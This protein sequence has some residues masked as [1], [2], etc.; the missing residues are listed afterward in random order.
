MQ[1]PRTVRSAAVRTP[2]R[3]LTLVELLVSIGLIIFIMS[4]F[5]SLFVQAGGALRQMTGINEIDQQARNLSTLLRRDL[6]DVF[7][8]TA[9]G[10]QITPAQLFA[11]PEDHDQV[12]A[13]YFSIEEN[14][15]ALGQG[16]DQWG[17]RVAV[18]T[19]DVL[20][21]TARRS[22]RSAQDLFFGRVPPEPLTAPAPPAVPVPQDGAPTQAWFDTFANAGGRF[23]ERGNGLFSSPF[24]EVAYF[25]RPEVGQ[26]TGDTLRGR[27]ADG[28]TTTPQPQRARTFV[29]CR[30]AL[31]V[32]PREVAL[33]ANR[34]PAAA[35]APLH[36]GGVPAGER[37]A[38]WHYNQYDLAAKPD[39]LDPTVVR[40]L[41]LDDLDRR[42]NRF[43]I[44]YLPGPAAQDFLS[45][46]DW[47]MSWSTTA[48]ATPAGGRVFDQGDTTGAYQ[49]LGRPLT[50]ETNHRIEDGGAYG[51]GADGANPA[52]IFDDLNQTFA[53]VN[54]DAN[55]DG[56]LDKGNADPAVQANA[57]D[58]IDDEYASGNSPAYTYGT[59]IL[60]RHVVSMNIEVL[61][62]DPR[63]EAYADLAD[64]TGAAPEDDNIAAPLP[65]VA[66]NPFRSRGVGAGAALA[67]WERGPTWVDLGYARPANPT[68]GTADEQFR[69][70]RERLDATAN[71]S[72]LSVRYDKGTAVETG[73]YEYQVNPSGLPTNAGDPHEGS[74]DA[75]PPARWRSPGRTERLENPP[76]T[77]LLTN[78]DTLPGGGTPTPTA[79]PRTYDSY[80]IDYNQNPSPPPPTPPAVGPAAFR[81]APYPKPLRA[82]RITVRVLE[83]TSGIT[84]EIEIVHHFERN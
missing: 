12:A 19:D 30:R 49:W 66:G 47:P 9:G 42:Q 36:S 22:G 39:P 27:A 65:S 5:A 77:V 8:A 35:G 50:L 1:H 56:I 76:G 82:I 6:D 52:S 11:S 16:V 33:A 68:G 84:R 48:G 24:G 79:L 3:G 43:G 23:D 41:S 13:G 73:S 14:S 28:T 57:F 51:N 70:G 69:V 80:S 7:M 29:L 58:E 38:T 72:L 83:P 37:A 4:I 21:F 18:D 55:L 45:Y 63:T 78:R 2:R 54:A 59:E 32:L 31:V 25:L 71:D 61:D 44:A 26:T 15:P 75:F 60:L 17:N 10:Q 20:A 34:A 62:D 46:V 53:A 74:P 67:D 64:D 81:A 40:F